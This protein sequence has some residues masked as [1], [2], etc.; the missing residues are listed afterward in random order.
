MKIV[1]DTYDSPLGTI[2]IVVDEI[3]VRR[4]ILFENEWL[5][6]R[7]KYNNIKQDRRLC[8]NVIRELDEYFN[9]ERR[10]F[11]VSLSIE[12]T[13]FRKKVWEALMNIPYG[14][15]RSYSQIAEAIGNP[16]AIR[17]VGQANKANLL[18]II[19]PCHRVV[20][21]SGELMGYAGNKTSVKKFLL[22]LEGV[23]I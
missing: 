11:Q 13:E 16:K 8:N 14:E 9:K 19:I 5:E 6:Y 2:Y 4:I 10:E 12:G 23:E 18:P 21:K 3:G 7:N 1:Y 15:V 20:G 22:E 17:A